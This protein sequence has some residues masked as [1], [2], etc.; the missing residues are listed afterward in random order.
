MTPFSFEH[1]FTTDCVEN[2]LTAYFDDE[3]QAE[4]VGPRAIRR[5]YSGAVSVDIA[6]VGGRIER[7]IVDE[8]AAG[9]A[10]AAVLTQG[11]LDKFPRS[12]AARA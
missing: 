12:V 9:L 3:L 1:E 7:G 8:L 11:W 6:L 10:R 5:R 2:V 4:Q